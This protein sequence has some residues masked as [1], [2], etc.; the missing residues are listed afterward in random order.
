MQL[1]AFV[2]Q[3]RVGIVQRVDPA[4]KRLS[5][6]YP[7]AKAFLCLVEFSSEPPP[8]EGI[9]VLCRMVEQDWVGISPIVLPML[10][11]FDAR[12]EYALLIHWMAKH[13]GPFNIPFDMIVQKYGTFHADRVFIENLLVKLRSPAFREARLLACGLKK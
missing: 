10:T 1:N 6:A 13:K 7:A 2:A 4:I 8:Q 9:E 12:Q 11:Y 5:S 3:S